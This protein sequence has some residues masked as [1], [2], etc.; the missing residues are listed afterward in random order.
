MG[1]SGDDNH[2]TA[3]GGKLVE[4]AASIGKGGTPC[5]M[6]STSKKNPW[7]RQSGRSTIGKN[8]IEPIYTFVGRNIYR[9]TRSN[10]IAN[11]LPMFGATIVGGREK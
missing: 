1:G 2:S 10:M 8:E 6:F 5:L 9:V 11:I 7:E 4:S 3:S